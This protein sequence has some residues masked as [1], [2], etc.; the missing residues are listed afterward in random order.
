VLRTTASAAPSAKIHY[1]QTIPFPCGLAVSA[2]FC[3]AR[4]GRGESSAW[5]PLYASAQLV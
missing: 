4:H 5:I 3:R 1:L 2:A